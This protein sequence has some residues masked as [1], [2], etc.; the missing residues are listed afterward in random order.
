[1]KLLKS[2]G[3][4]RAHIY[5][6]SINLILTVLGPFY[7]LYTTMITGVNLK[8]RAIMNTVAGIKILAGFLPF[9]IKKQTL[10]I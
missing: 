3:L 4:I 8:I 7:P 5:L 6:I 10:Y 1:M 2:I 9:L